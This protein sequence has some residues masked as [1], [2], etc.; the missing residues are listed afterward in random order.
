MISALEFQMMQQRCEAARGAPSQPVTSTSEAMEHEAV[1][2][3]AIADYCR[4]QEWIFVHSRMDERTTFTHIQGISDFIIIRKHPLPPMAI[5]AKAKYRKA[6][7]DQ[8][9]FIA[10]FR[11]LGG[12]A[13][14]VW[15][16]DEFLALTKS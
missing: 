9:A 3:E 16:F 5:E 7:P 13:G 6:T 10:W 1:L 14:V 12:V 2:H 15:S 11:K 8:E 4:K